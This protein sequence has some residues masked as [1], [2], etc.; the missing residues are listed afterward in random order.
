MSFLRRALDFWKSHKLHFNIITAFLVL[1]IGSNSLI[2]FYS[3]FANR[4]AVM[5]FSKDIMSQVSERSIHKS[6]SYLE[7]ARKIS[8]LSKRMI[9]RPA[10]IDM[11]SNRKLY[12]YFAN[13]LTEYSHIDSLYAGAQN[14]DFLYVEMIRPVREYF[15]KNDPSKKIPRNVKYIVQTIKRT[16]DS[17]IQTYYYLD[18]NKNV[19]L[20]E[21][22][23]KF[24]YDHRAR[25]WYLNVAQSRQFSWSNIYI[26]A[27]YNIPGI[28]AS[29]PLVSNDAGDS[30]FGVIGADLTLGDYSR[31]LANAQISDQSLVFIF[32]N[33][34]EIIAH[35]DPTKGVLIQGAPIEAQT[36]QALDRKEIS[37]AYELFAK[38]KDPLIIFEE[39]GV[40]YIASFTPF[41]KDF[42]YEWYLCIVA[43]TDEFVG[44]INESYRHNL[45]MAITIL[46][47]SAFLIYFL[48]RRISRPIVLISQEIKRLQNFDMS[49]EIDFKSNVYEIQ[50]I[51]EAMA[52]LKKSLSAF[53]KFVPKALVQKLIAK[54]G[55]IK[56]GGKEKEL[57]LFFSDIVSFTSISENMPPEKLALHL[58]EYLNE[59][60][61]IIM[62]TGGTIDKYI[63]DAIMAFWGAPIHDSNH[64]YN[65][66]KAALMCQKR[67]IELNRKWTL[68]GKPVL[69]TR[70]GLHTH[71]VIVGNIGS[72]ERM[73]YTV[74]GDGVN[75]AAR[76]EGV[77]KL[78]GTKIIASGV[79]YERLKSKFLFRPVDVVAVK[80]KKESVIIYE[81]MAQLVDEASLLP[82]E[83]EMTLADLTSK[84]FKLYL[85][86]RWDEA[87]GLIET[88]LKR[89][90]ADSV[91]TL[92]AER[93]NAFKLNPPGEN[94]DG[95]VHLTSK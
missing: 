88:G 80:G 2:I 45:M 18:H 37:R 73:N 62:Q 86:Q 58:S 51:R 89:F 43:P 30:F 3:Y 53:G 92:L 38:S 60:S 14:G 17:P 68:E 15:F 69:H 26:F 63:G 59:L 16:V 1:L 71:S 23:N 49:G 90:A 9:T 54:G 4:S 76:L 39:D 61:H 33:L 70:I 91:L 72:E 44:V 84:A 29:A 48:S 8:I 40:E 64:M 35:P 75:L 78:Y 56:L 41:P 95:S 6:V 12:E 34:G 10:E 85:E 77:N 94:W 83:E 81:L 11:E 28:T 79:M 87:L 93:C 57:S 65:A 46:I 50:S 36:V 27:V 42:P 22:L 31:F 55:D 21:T 74:L 19:L 66:C 20:K 5:E 47:L 67:L 82:S 24:N 52:A 32:N 7:S 13:V 25:D